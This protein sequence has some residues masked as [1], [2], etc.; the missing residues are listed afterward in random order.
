VNLIVKRRKL[1]AI[2]TTAM[3]RCVLWR[4][5]VAE[6]LKHAV[7]HHLPE[8]R[9]V[10]GIGANCRQSIL[11][12]QLASRLRVPARLSRLP[13]WHRLRQCSLGI[14]RSKANAD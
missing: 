7:L 14:Y 8:A 6:G 11:A 2:L 5:H 3:W 9:A 10:A 13:N 12:A 4:Q 1:A